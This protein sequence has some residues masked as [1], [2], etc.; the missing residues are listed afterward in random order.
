[1]D[2]N[3][4]VGT[5]A[6]VGLRVT[7]AEG[8]VSEQSGDGIAGRIMYHPDGNLAMATRH[9]NGD[10]LVYFGRYEIGD[11]HVIHHIELSPKEDLIG[12]AQRRQVSFRDG[13]LVLTASPSIA[14]GPG[15]MA[16]ITWQRI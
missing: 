1:V 12:T 13:R 4:F 10:Y 2:R 16:D 6:L 5:W 7:D 11:D 9:R 14:G 3:D 15:S 8:K